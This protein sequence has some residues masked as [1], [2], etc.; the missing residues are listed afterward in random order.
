MT[1]GEELKRIREEQGVTQH[2]LARASGVNR[3]WISQVELDRIKSPPTDKIA[4]I[5]RAFG[6][7]MV[8]LASRMGLI[9]EAALP[10]DVNATV[11]RFLALLTRLDPARRAAA[12]AYMTGIESMLGGELSTIITPAP[13]PE[14]VNHPETATK[15]EQGKSTKEQK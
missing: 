12:I 5:A 3:A 10:A 4:K 13:K 14:P 7:P 9:T 6:M 15:T 2:Q 1:A 11:E 8:E